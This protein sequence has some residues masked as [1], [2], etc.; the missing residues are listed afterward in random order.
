MVGFYANSFPWFELQCPHFYRS[1]SAQD[2]VNNNSGNETKFLDAS[3]RFFT[4]I[5]HDFGMRS[6]PILNDIELIKVGKRHL[7]HRYRNI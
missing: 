3:N 5:P 4:L 6:P 7:F 1:F 2:M